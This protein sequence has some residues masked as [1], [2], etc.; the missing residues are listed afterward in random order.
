MGS[1]QEQRPISRIPHPL[2]QA[3]QAT[4]STVLEEA[5]LMLLEAEGLLQAIDR[6]FEA[7]PEN[8][9]AEEQPAGVYGMAL[10]L[11]NHAIRL[12]DRLNA[13]NVRF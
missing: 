1:N 7:M 3:E 5:Q 8:E 9:T 10:F 4:L 13:L 12:R 6:R 2:G 11:R